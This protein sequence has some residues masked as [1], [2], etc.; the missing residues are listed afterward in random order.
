M[1]EKNSAVPEVSIRDYVDMLR[2]RK[3]IVIQT[4][5]V[6]FVIGAVVTFMSKPVYRT[7]TR[8]LVE[9]NG[10]GVSTNGSGDPLQGFQNREVTHD[11]LTQLEILQGAELMRQAY[12]D[13]G[14][15]P[16]TV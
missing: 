6:V 4:F 2:R 8:I 16:G 1:E 5:V 13:A 15:P 9:G 7:S 14:V 11:V 10:S 3:A 12:V